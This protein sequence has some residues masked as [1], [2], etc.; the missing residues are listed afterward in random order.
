MSRRR[1]NA[2]PTAPIDPVQLVTPAHGVDATVNTIPMDKEVVSPNITARRLHFSEIS[3]PVKPLP[4][5]AEV[6]RGNRNAQMG[7]SLS[8]MPPIERDGQRVVRISV[9]DFQPQIDYWANAL[10]GYVIDDNPNAKMME[11]FMMH[12][13]NFVSKPQILMHAEGYCIF[14]FNSEE[15]KELVIQSGPYSYR[16]KPM[17]LKPWEIDFSFSNDVLSTIPVWIRFPGLPVGYWSTDV[18]SKLA[19]AVGRPLYT[20]KITAHYEKISFA[21]VLVEVDA[22]HPLPDQIHIDTP[23]GMKI[24]Q[25]EYD[26]KPSFCNHCLKFGHDS[27]DCWYNAGKDQEVGDHV[28]ERKQK[29]NI[30]NLIKRTKQE[31]VPKSCADAI[32]NLPVQPKQT[33]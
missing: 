18:L 5:V 33:S 22:A 30:P 23:F 31:W 13:W 14:R 4:T 29:A 17:V 3:D 25:I 20:D 2:G 11:N 1:R 7:K 15:D 24:Q 28:K 26:W 12:V 32:A 19:S 27:I 16:N 8:F 10:I 6:V 21:R 9:E